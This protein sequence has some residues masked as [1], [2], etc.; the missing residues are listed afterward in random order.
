MV[1]FLSELPYPWCQ[2]PPSGQPRH[3]SCY[4]WLQVAETPTPMDLNTEE[5]YYHTLQGSSC[6]MLPGLVGVPAQH[7]LK[8]SGS[9]QCP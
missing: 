1:Q 2:M 3:C 7:I 4:I 5:V 6:R 9:S 8:D